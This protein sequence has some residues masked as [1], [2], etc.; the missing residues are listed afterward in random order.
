MIFNNFPKVSPNSMKARIF[1]AFLASAGL[2]YVNIMPAIVSGLIEALGFTNQ[3][4][5]NIASANMYGAAA[6]ALL[7]V[8][9]IKR[10]NW[11]LTSVIFLTGLIAIDLYS[12]ALTDPKTLLMVRFIH[13]FIGGMLVGTGF[14]LIAR[15]NEPDRTFGVLL[16][17]QFGLG[18]LGIMFIPGMVPEYGTQILFYSLVAFSVATFLM[19]PFLPAY[20]IKPE[21]QS[22]T[23]KAGIHWAPLVLTLATIFLFQAANMGL[24]AFIIGL[25]EHYDLGLGFI[26]TTL[27]IANW[28]GVAGAG[29]VIVIGSRFG[30][31]KSI[32]AG[33]VFTAIGIWALLYSNIPWI[34]IASNCLIGITWGFTISY[35]LGL[36]SR[37][38]SSG[39]M[40]A[41]GGFASKM[42]LA[43]GPVITAMLLGK[44][45][46]QLIIIVSTIVM[47]LTAITVWIPARL[48]D[49][50]KTD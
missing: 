2:F 39:Q 19:L 11:Q 42:G 21:K 4:A 32:M 22:V 15:T 35:L 1:L 12:I 8:F 43:S 45:N 26:S 23:S 41:L 38:D 34:W 47:L 10:L 3:E 16:F 50:V 30:Y 17:V 33:I 27:G 25:G 40:A 29:L 36:A 48:Q 37:F 44:D 6:G 49:H 31:L 18:G 9:L 5:G 24:F 20:A 46:Y 13:G 28:L 14:S 7:I